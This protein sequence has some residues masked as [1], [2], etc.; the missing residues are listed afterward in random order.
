MEI[1]SHRVAATVFYILLTLL[2]PTI[3]TLST[4]NEPAVVNLNS[5]NP[6]PL[7]YTVSLSLFV[8]PMLVISWWFLRRPGVP[9]KKTAFWRTTF[10]LVPVGV[11]LDLLFGNSFFEFGNHNAVLGLTFPALGGPL[12]VEELVFYITGFIVIL[13]IYIWCDEYWL[14]LY[15][16]PDYEKEVHT[17][18]RILR[19]H[20]R[21]LLV[22]GILIVAAIIYKKF[23]A[24]NPEGFPWYFIYLV[25]VSM[26]PSSAFYDSV[27]PFINWRAFSFTM[28]IVVLISLIWEVTLA[29][30]Y[31]WWDFQASAMM[32]IHIKAWYQLPLEEPFLWIAVSYTTVIIFEVMKIWLASRKPFKQ[33]FTGL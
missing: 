23:L 29:L 9:F 7:G 26:I 11:I 33:A 2:L 24:T 31:Q 12:P 14:S 25:V 27:R 18:D 20:P 3:L 21:S 19:F 15:N 16:V 13:L 8:F 22:G 17:V 32:G 6:T 10:F 4:V 30:P 1:K 5:A 28:F